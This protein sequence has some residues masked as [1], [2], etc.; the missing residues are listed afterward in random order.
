MS[1]LLRATAWLFVDC[2]RRGLLLFVLAPVVVA[3][4][5]LPEFIQ[6]V[7]EIG[8]GMFDS[9]AAARAASVHPDRWL[10]GYFKIA[11]LVAT[12]LCAARFWSTRE[13]GGRWWRIDDMRWGWLVVGIAVV[14]LPSLAI[15]LLKSGLPALGYQIAQW[16]VSIA[17]LPGL[18]V[19]VAAIVGDRS[20]TFRRI[21][22]HSWLYLPLLFA[23]LIVAFAPA[24]ILH[25]QL[26][27]WAIGVPV[28]MV[29]GLMT[30][31]ALLVGL[32]ASLTGAAL[33]LGYRSFARGVV[34]SGSHQD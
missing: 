10:A 24:Q 28:A 11:G 7:V 2:Y 27:V 13:H 1:A 31:D 22:T 20:M 21:S 34:E 33:Y 5:V 14:V 8:L 9:R 30:L 29:W 6:H 19:I 15:E 12:I 17:T 32:L 18:F 25:G 26:H 3:L 16:T 23:L 4:A